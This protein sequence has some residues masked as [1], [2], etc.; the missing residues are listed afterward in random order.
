MS[1]LT[2]LPDL[3]VPRLAERNSISDEWNLL[4]LQLQERR[5]SGRKR[6]EPLSSHMYSALLVKN[7]EQVWVSKAILTFGRVV[8]GLFIVQKIAAIPT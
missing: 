5:L 3:P 4:P 6:T 2:E 1:D 7:F 8:H